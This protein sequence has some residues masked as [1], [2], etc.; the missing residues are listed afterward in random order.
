LANNSATGGPLPAQP[1]FP[2]DDDALDAV[3]QALVASVTGLPGS[4]V[5]PRWQ[6]G[7]P[8]QPEPGTDWCA[9]GVV[10][11]VPSA[12]PWLVYDPVN[13][14][15]QYWDHEEFSVLASHYGP[16]AKFYARLLRAGLN[17]PQNTEVLLPFEMRYIGCGHVRN[18]PELINLQ[19][20]HR[21]DLAL[22]FRRKFQLVYAVEN[23]LVADVNLIDDTIVNDTIIVP[24][25]SPTV[26]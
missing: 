22:T 25:G 24:P 8:K 16:N 11:T 3:L 7:N 14:V 21:Q 1:P 12:G 13:N 2:V 15:E 17:V 6:P 10:D 23:I 19:W 5:R 9:V 26:P 18:V 4:L 20:V